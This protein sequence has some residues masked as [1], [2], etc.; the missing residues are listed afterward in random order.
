MEDILEAAERAI[1]AVALSI[2]PNQDL[3]GAILS[4]ENILQ[5]LYHLHPLLHNSEHYV[6]AVD[7]VNRMIE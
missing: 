1:T 6:S 2:T 3:D 4:L 7:S 5:R